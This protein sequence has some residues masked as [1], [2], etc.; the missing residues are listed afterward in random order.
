[1]TVW[2]ICATVSA[3]AEQVMAFVAHH[4]DLG[5]DRIWLNFD[6]PDDPAFDRVARLAR[7][8][9]RRCDAAWWQETCGKRPGAHQNRQSRNVQRLCAGAP[10]PWIAHLDHD[11]FLVAG[12]PVSSVLEGVPPEA[13]MLRMAPF[14]ALQAPD[15]ADDIFTARA[16]RGALR[17]PSHAADRGALF[18][19]H[20]ALLPDGMLSHSVGK[21]FFRTGIAGLQPRIHGAF[22][23][24]QRV[25]GGA[26][27]PDLALLHF[28]AEDRAR[29]LARLPFRLARGGY[30]V[31][32]LQA[33]AGAGPD[34]LAEFYDAV[35][36][37]SEPQL[38]RMRNLGIL[39]EERL[40]LRRKVAALTERAST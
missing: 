23:D 11:E 35:Q 9:A 3:P 26:F 34:A 38:A 40:E 14:E 17:G 12:R 33:L 30:R 28:H 16:F 32:P 36:T 31:G 29:W 2:G 19:R 13:P 18:G 27:A 22:R 25:P 6:D 24:G 5:A 39:R 4:L 10:L 21:S 7:V 20:A 15:M 1:M 37:A 8:S